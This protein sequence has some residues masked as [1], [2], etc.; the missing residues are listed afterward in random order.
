MDECNV[1]GTYV[2]IY[3]YLVWQMSFGDGTIFDSLTIPTDLEIGKIEFS[4]ILGNPRH[5]ILWGIITYSGIPT[6]NKLFG[7]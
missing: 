5:I 3:T 7:N 2:S 6:G 1:L 4:V